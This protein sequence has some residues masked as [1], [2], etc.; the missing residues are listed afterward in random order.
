VDVRLLVIDLIEKASLLVTAGLVSVITPPLRNRLLG[1]GRP[2][3]RFAPGLLGVAL[4]MWG[5]LLGDTWG[6]VHVHLRD[7]G[8]LLAAA[9]GGSRAG[10][11]AGALAGL[12]YVFRVDQ[13]GGI[14]A[15]LASTISGLLA[16][17]VVERKPH[18]FQGLRALWTAT[19]VVSVGVLV[20]LV[21][22]LIIGLPPPGVTGYMAMSLL[23][24]LNACGIALMLAVARL[25]LQREEHARA[26][27]EVRAAAN[28]LALESLRRRL[29]PHFLFNALNTLRALIRTDPFTA[30]EFVADLA[31]LYRY[32]LHH[33]D[34]AKLRD[35][36]EHARAYL[37]I[38]RA[39]LGGDR[40]R[41]ETTLPDALA[42]RAGARPLAPAHRGERRQTRHRDAARR[43]HDSHRRARRGR[44]HHHRGARP[45]RRRPSRP[46]GEGVGHRARR[47][48]REPRAPIR[49]R[50]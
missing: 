33:P 29:E 38:E 32:L 26:L 22:D 50:R 6:G 39:R 30:R 36:M 11:T 5:S 19:G 24:A 15:I 43:R 10:L 25:V 23:V 3:D 27:V 41:I 48:P 17:I 14:A 45:R 47:A 44:P 12:F 8:V 35:E 16:G 13:A 21:G 31:D 7:V 20:G 42:R 4:A 46:H 2:R 1:L 34:L 9:L 18:A 28:E 40:L 49:R 37:T